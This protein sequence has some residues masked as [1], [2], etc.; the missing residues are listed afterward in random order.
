MRS[1][2]RSDA[3]GPLGRDPHRRLLVLV[4]GRQA[5]DDVRAVGDYRGGDSAMTHWRDRSAYPPPATRIG[6][7]CGC[8]DHF[9]DGHRWFLQVASGS[10]DLLIVAV[11]S[12]AS[13]ARLKGTGR[14]AWKL[15]TRLAIVRQYCDAA[16][17]FE[18]EEEPLLAAI[19]P[20][21]L[22][23]GFDQDRLR[24]AECVG[25]VVV[26]DRHG[27]TSTTARLKEARV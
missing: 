18:G 24:G 19:R 1:G 25:E 13:V 23:R 9:H 16:I 7:T 8:F 5:F 3:L 6:F 17:P 27:D 10:C 11:N 14:P 20:A 12:D 4:L 2:R 22:Y 26:L 15:A 21:V